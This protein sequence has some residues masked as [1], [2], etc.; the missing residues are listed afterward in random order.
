MAVPSLRIPRSPY[1]SRVAHHFN[2]HPDM[3]SMPWEIS[4]PSDTIPHPLYSKAG[5]HPGHTSELVL[6]PD[7]SFGIVALA[8]GADTN[9]GL[10]AFE[11]ERI[12]TPLLQYVVGEASLRMYA[13]IYRMQC[14][15]DEPDK[16]EVVIEAASQIKITRLRDCDGR[17]GFARIDHRCESTECFAKLWDTGREGEFRFENSWSALTLVPRSFLTGEDV[18]GH[19]LDSRGQW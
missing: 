18:I 9:A 2:T 3:C 5:S 6:S 17:D 10:L 4:L 11:T 16:G 12:V 13:G 8:C 15:H 14:P 19:G 7:L 1:R